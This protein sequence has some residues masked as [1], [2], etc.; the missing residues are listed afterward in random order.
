MTERERYFQAKVD[1]LTAEAKAG[2]DVVTGPIRY[3]II[4]QPTVRPDIQ[5]V[6]C[7]I[8]GVCKPV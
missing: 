4:S 5:Q 6:A 8:T 1:K 7:P 2:P 3:S